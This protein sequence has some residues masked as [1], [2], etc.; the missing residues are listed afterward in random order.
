MRRTA[1]CARRAALLLPVLERHLE[2]DL[3]GRRAAVGVEDA[4]QS[5]RRDPDQPLG[6]L[7]RG[8]MGEAEHRRVRDTVELRLHRRVDVRVPVAVD[9]APE[10]R[11]AVD[12]APAVRVD[13]LGPLG[14]LDDRR[15]LRRPSPLL[16]EGVPDVLAIGLSKRIRHGPDASYRA[17]R[18]AAAPAAR[19][20]GRD[21]LAGSGDRGRPAAR[22]LLWRVDDRVGEHDRGGARRAVGRVLARRPVGRPQPDDARPLPRGARGARRSS[23]SCRSRPIRCSTSRWTRWTRSPRARSSAR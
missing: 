13:Q 10:R 20:R 2:G 5:G 14:A 12:V 6:Q 22:S 9:G 23:R 8:R 3:R 1:S 4:V 16:G 11:G 7:D 17:G 15:V 19:F 21:G 18:N